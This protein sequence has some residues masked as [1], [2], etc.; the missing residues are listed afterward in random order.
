MEEQER[1]VIECGSVTLDLTIEEIRQT[2][3]NAGKILFENN[4]MDQELFYG[5]GDNG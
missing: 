5:G 2:F 1:F 3:I 4:Q